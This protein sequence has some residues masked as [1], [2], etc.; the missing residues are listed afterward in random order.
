[1]DT[2]PVTRGNDVVL[3]SSKPCHQ[4]SS[5][6]YSTENRRKLFR[7][8]SGVLSLAQSC[9]VEIVICRAGSNGAQ[10]CCSLFSRQGSG[11][12][13]CLR[14]LRIPKQDQIKRF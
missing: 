7:S 6:P 9:V 14:R 1:M 5:V 3:K 13:L 11:S 10:S 12:E 2:K 4:T 8:C